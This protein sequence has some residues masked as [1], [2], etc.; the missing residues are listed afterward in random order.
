M[1]FGQCYRCST[2]FIASSVN[3]VVT[4]KIHCLWCWYWISDDIHPWGK[5][6]S[7]HNYVQFHVCWRPKVVYVNFFH[8]GFFFTVSHN[9]QNTN[10]LFKTL[11][12]L[13]GCDCSS[14]AV[15]P[16][17]SLVRDKP[18]ETPLAPATVK[19]EWDLKNLTYDTL[20]SSILIT[21]DLMGGASVT[22]LRCG[23]WTNL[24]YLFLFYIFQ[25]HQNTVYLS[26]ITLILT[27]VTTVITP[28]GRGA[29]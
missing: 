24:M 22:T 8:S 4:W 13:D 9:H 12:T 18:A 15:T 19:Y 20:I 2:R 21:D 29:L 10:F 3:E 6:Y 11:F 1:R 14:A 23:G 7:G 28:G 17:S 16:V 25:Y 5:P 26:L 27:G